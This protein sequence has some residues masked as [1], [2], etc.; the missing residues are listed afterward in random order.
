MIIGPKYVIINHQDTDFFTIGGC[1]DRTRY[2]YEYEQDNKKFSVGKTNPIVGHLILFEINNISFSRG[3]ELI[4][5][6]ENNAY[7]FERFLIK[8]MILR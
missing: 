8:H 7:E 5:K 3:R 6:F 2:W 1:F 4:N